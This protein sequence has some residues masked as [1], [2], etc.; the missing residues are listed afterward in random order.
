[1]NGDMSESPV[2]VLITEATPPTVPQTNLWMMTIP[3][4]IAIFGSLFILLIGNRLQRRL[5][6]EQAERARKF[7]ALEDITQLAIDCGKDI[8]DAC[9]QS[10]GN[11]SPFAWRNSMGKLDALFAVH[12]P[13]EEQTTLKE[14]RVAYWSAIDAAITVRS[15]RL[16][17]PNHAQLSELRQRRDVE[18]KQ[19]HEKD[20]NLF[21]SI[22][23][24]AKAIHAQKPSRWWQRRRSYSIKP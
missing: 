9:L 15:A 14:F 4:V 3:S 24:M 5:Q 21:E 2:S 19:Y 1:M 18:S 22:A 6:L 11:D 23:K 10:E 13:D 17:S 12:F 20:K 7:K 16:D 8:S